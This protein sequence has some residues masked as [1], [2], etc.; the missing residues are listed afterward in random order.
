MKLRTPDECTTGTNPNAPQGNQVTA[1]N[2]TQEVIDL[3]EDLG[4]EG[5]VQGDVEIEQNETEQSDDDSVP[6]MIRQRNWMPKEIVEVLNYY[7]GLPEGHTNKMKTVRWART[8]FKRPKFDKKRVNDWLKIEDKIRASAATL[9]SDRARLSLKRQPVG[10]YSEMENI[11][12]ARIR[13]MRKGGVLVIEMWMVKEDAKAILHDLYPDRFP[14]VLSD[15]FLFKF[16][17]TWRDNR[18]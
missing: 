8:K 14:D 7:H 2:P 9:G 3:S 10:L 6:I 12:A 1:G 5:C 17:N 13:A 4:N 15:D 16:S 18:S 11:L